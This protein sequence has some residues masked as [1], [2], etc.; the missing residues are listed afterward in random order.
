MGNYKDDRGRVQL[1][2][3]IVIRLFSKKFDDDRDCMEETS[4]YC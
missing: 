3:K 2:E 4:S 1:K